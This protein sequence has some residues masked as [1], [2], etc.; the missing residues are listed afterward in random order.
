MQDGAIV[1]N[2]IHLVCVDHHGSY[3]HD[4]YRA[5]SM[6]VVI[7]RSWMKA[8]RLAGS[9]ATFLICWALRCGHSKAIEWAQTVSCIH[10]PTERP[11]GSGS[12]EQISLSAHPRTQSCGTASGNDIL[13]RE[14]RLRS[15]H[16]SGFP[17][18][19]PFHFSATPRFQNYMEGYQP[20]SSSKSTISEDYRVR[21]LFH[22]PNFGHFSWNCPDIMQASETVVPD[23]SSTDVDIERGS[24]SVLPSDPF[25]LR[26]GLKTPAELRALR[27]RRK[28][29]RVAKYQRKQNSVRPPAKLHSW[30]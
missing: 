28:G 19:F 21:L 23:L 10:L 25:Q 14:I 5:R 15:F 6:F 3:G 4:G 29:K 30:Q 26:D 22:A 18:P 7:T 13:V 24:T 20:S 2:G 1:F 27:H 11:K 9:G 17:T 12:S 8:P 16:S